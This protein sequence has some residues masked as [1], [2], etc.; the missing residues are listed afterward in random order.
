MALRSPV[1][2]MPGS[3]RSSGE[4]ISAIFSPP[5]IKGS[6][7]RSPCR[8]HPRRCNAV[9]PLRGLRGVQY[10]LSCN[11]SW[12]G[13]KLLRLREVGAQPLSDFKITGRIREVRSRSWKPLDNKG[14]KFFYLAVNVFRPIAG[15]GGLAGEV[16][17]FQ[18]A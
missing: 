9:Q 2:S 12:P 15:D 4:S 14:R 5:G 3:L 16:V 18:L 6:N 11:D 17:R 10:H 8:H 13:K 1:D 7:P